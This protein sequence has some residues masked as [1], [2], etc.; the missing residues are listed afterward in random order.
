MILTDMSNAM[1]SY[2]LFPLIFLGALSLPISI[3]NQEKPVESLEK[4]PQNSSDRTQSKHLFDQLDQIQN[5]ETYPLKQD[6]DQHDFDHHHDFQTTW[7]D[8]HPQEDTDSFES[9]FFNMLMILGLLIGFMFLASWSLKRMMKSKMTHMNSASS[10]KV[11]ETRYLSPRATLYL[12]ELQDQSFLIAES[13][14]SVTYLKAFPL[15]RED[16]SPFPSKKFQ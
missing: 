14:T 6:I 10:I 11:L 8:H 1:K 2:L 15:Q 4:N 5:F 9:K 13:P 7:P 12:I 3:Y 16:P